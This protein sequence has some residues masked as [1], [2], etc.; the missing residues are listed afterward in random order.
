M[1]EGFLNCWKNL[2][3][4]INKLAILMTFFGLVSSIVDVIYS[5]YTY[6]YN[7]VFFGSILIYTLIFANLKLQGVDY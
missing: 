2:M 7:R 5:F 1:I 3:L 6:N 4:I